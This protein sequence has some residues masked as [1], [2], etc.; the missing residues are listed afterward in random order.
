MKIA[1][2]SEGLRVAPYFGSATSYMCYT[3]QRG[4]IT[5]CQN[6]PNQKLSLDNLVE[7]FK[8]LGIDVVIT[9]RIEYA[10]AN[11]LCHSG[12]EVVAGAN[13]NAG[14]IARG[15][16]SKTLTGVEEVCHIADPT[17]TIGTEHS[18]QRSYA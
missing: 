13:G 3:V 8:E 7:L 17:F 10:I 2:A 14:D 12:I 15:Y 5:D 18:E 1:V 6:M 4:I 9:G 11:K 16:L